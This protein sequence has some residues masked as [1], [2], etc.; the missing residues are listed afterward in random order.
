MFRCEKCNKVSMP[1]EKSNKVVIEKRDKT[2]SYKKGYEE[3]TAH[4][5][6]IQKEITVCNECV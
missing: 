1:R 6:E 5:W 4:G 2:Y 3:R